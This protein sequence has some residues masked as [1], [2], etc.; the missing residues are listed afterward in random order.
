MLTLPFTRHF[1]N[2]SGYF[3]VVSILLLIGFIVW[4]EK[5]CGIISYMWEVLRE[6]KDKG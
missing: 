6:L 3:F 5:E 1:W 4:M 2:F